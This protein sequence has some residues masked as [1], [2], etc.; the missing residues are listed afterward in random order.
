MASEGAASGQ[1]IKVFTRQATGLVREASWFDAALYNFFGAAIPVTL[2]YVFLFGPA[3]YPGADL[4]VSTLIALLLTLP[5]ALIFALLQAA[6]PRAGGDY[7]WLSR[8]VHPAVGFASNLSTSLWYCFFIALN[9]TLLGTAALAPLLRVIAGTTGSPDIA[10][11]AEF[12]LSAPGVIVIGIAVIGLA[13][14]LLTFGRGLRTYLRAQ[15]ITGIYWILATVF[16]AAV[17]VFLVDATTFEERFDQYIANLGGPADAYQLV[18]TEGAYSETPV[19]ARATV[20]AQT[21]PFYALGFIFISAYLGGEIRES[22]YSTLLAMP[23]AQIVAGI[24][25]FI[26]IAAYLGSIGNPFLASLGVVDPAMYGLTSV[27]NYLE[28]AAIASGSSVLGIVMMAGMV[29]YFLIIAAVPMI[30]V[31]R[32]ILAWGIDRLVPERLA[33]VNE[34]THSPVAAIVLVSI[35][36]I[37]LVVIL[38]LDPSLTGLVGLLGL[39]LTYV[40]VG[41]AG[42]LF[43]YRRRD[44]FET[45]PFSGRVAGVPWVALVGVA[46]TVTSLGLVAILLI[47]ENS[48]TSLSLNPDRALFAIA[49]F[50]GGIPV[51]YL[52]RAIQRR[53]GV[54]IELAYKEIPPD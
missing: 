4:R 35:V 21:L 32:N 41:V 6:I 48:G 11:A 31:S 15:K 5:S 22:R 46:A 25:I 38:A 7:A 24:T 33:D 12:A 45:S 40:A 49:V 50:L 2:V 16:L 9:A 47:D 8:I 29:A 27:P 43:P 30:L 10:S 37:V 34:S 39:V 3:F 36:S 19:D 51:W 1:P 28:L 53:R 17:V 23:G 26:V 14:V 18:L 52:I 20:L 54:N 44:L 42:L 13:A